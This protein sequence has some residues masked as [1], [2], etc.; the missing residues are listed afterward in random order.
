MSAGATCRRWRREE[1]TTCASG[2]STSAWSFRIS[3]TGWLEL[4]HGGPTSCR[5][6]S[7][8]KGSGSNSLWLFDHLQFAAPGTTAGLIGPWECWS[9]LAALAAATSHIT[10]GTTVLCTS[11]RNPALLAKMADTTDEISGG[12]VIL[13]LG[14]GWNDVEYRAFGY[15]VDQR[16]SRFEEAVTIITTLLREGQIDFAGQYYQ[17]RD[18]VLRPRGPRPTGPPI[19]IGSSLGPRMLRLTARYADLWNAWAWLHHN[20]PSGIP[21]LHTAVDAACIAVGRSPHTLGRT[22]AVLVE[23]AGAV[24]YPQDYPGWNPGERGRPVAGSAEAIAEVFRGFAREGVAHLQV[25]VNPWTVRGVE[26]LAAVLE[27]LDR[28]G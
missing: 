13:G 4:R 26:S 8:P 3:N 7:V 22:A 15:P 19:L 1:L 25:W 2:H 18:C 5:L 23:G 11:F 14:A 28:D 9:L 21:W 10:L 24:P 20:S 17:A 27:V 12:R 16:V 6:R